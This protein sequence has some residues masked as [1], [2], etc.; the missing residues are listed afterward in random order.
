LRREQRCFTCQGTWTPSHT[1]GGLKEDEVM[2][3]SSLQPYEDKDEGE[4]PIEATKNEDMCSE[5]DTKTALNTHLELSNEAD[6]TSANVGIVEIINIPSDD[7]HIESKYDDD[8]KT[9]SDDPLYYSGG[10]GFNFQT[11]SME[12]DLFRKRTSQE[13]HNEQSNHPFNTWDPGVMTPKYDEDLTLDEFSFDR[14]DVL[15]LEHNACMEDG[16]DAVDLFLENKSDVPTHEA[17][18]VQRFRDFDDLDP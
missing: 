3:T 10:V 7:G 18:F 2:L 17:N 13:E 1:C 14:G 12:S 6:N 5:S 16:I 4:S 8:I 9:A 15:I 11:K